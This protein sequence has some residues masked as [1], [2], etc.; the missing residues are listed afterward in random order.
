[1][2]AIQCYRFLIGTKIP[3]SDWPQIVQAFLNQQSL[4][5]ERFLYYFEDNCGGLPKA[6]KDCPQLGPI[7][8][9][10]AKSENIHYLSNIEDDT[11]CTKADI[12]SLMPKI[13]RRYGF[14][15]THIIY[16]D[17]NFFSQNIPAIVQAPGNTPSCIK[18]SSITCYRDSVFPR[19]S[20][21]DLSIVIYDGEKTFDPT[22]Y[23]DAMK[24]L[25]PGVRY[26]GFVECCMS[27]DELRAYETLNADA[28]ALLESARNHLSNLLP[29]MSEQ[30]PNG[31]N[32]PKLS[33]AP[34]LKKLCKQYGYEYVKCE[35][36]HYFI[37]KRTANGHSI[38]LEVDVGPS[39]KGVGLLV[40][41]VGVG[42]DH[43]IASSF[44]YP[45]DQ[46]DLE[47]YLLQCF[48]ALASAEKEVLPALDAHF[49][50]T[51]DW[52]TPLM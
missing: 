21:I 36:F 34:V 13:Y 48:H 18:G 7:R 49:P 8:W 28:A 3:F 5:H 44:G 11:G 9:R 35:Y 16:Q 43:R 31:L 42:F 12:L 29:T 4:H 51:P 46:I 23:F 30:L 33:A 45:Q 22:P 20:S 25:L 52:F 32:T 27:E 24:Q 14:S 26:F 15:E 41:Y 19:W 1:M 50:A 2:L 39:F 37:T 47:N 6:L 10:P 38:M 17:I 40:R